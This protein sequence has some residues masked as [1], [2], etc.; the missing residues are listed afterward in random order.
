MRLVITVTDSTITSGMMMKLFITI[1]ALIAFSTAARSQEN[2]L[3]I[4]PLTGDFYIYTTYKLI[5]GSP[6]PSN[7]MYIVTDS[8]VVLIDTPWDVAQTY[9]LLDSIQRRHGRRVILCLATHSHD[10]RT[11][12]LDIL[13][14]EGV[15]TYS[16]AN[17]LRLCRKSG[18]KQAE[19]S[20]DRDTTFKVGN[21]VFQ[22]FYPGAG[23]TEDNI[24]VWFPEKK[25]LYGG[26]FIKSTESGGLGY[27]A[28]ANLG[29]WPASIRKVKKKFPRPAF[30]IP[31]H[32]DWENPKSLD[33]TLRLLKE[34]RRKNRN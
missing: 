24:V 11:A 17:T 23:H 29:Q 15:R 9:P 31:G 22:T 10:D 6:F 33:H 26:C 20:F 30:V 13:R 25:V 21:V 1:L 8:G 32:Q 7:S 3:T 12:G 5:N 16:T 34:A 18:D 14:K 4:T 2:A 28:D 27:I 19:F